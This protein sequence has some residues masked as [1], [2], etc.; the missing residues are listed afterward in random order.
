MKKSFMTTARKAQIAL[1]IMTAVSCSFIG[2]TANADFTGKDGTSQSAL[3][4]IAIGNNTQTGMDTNE[5]AIGTSAN[6]S[7]GS[8]IA[9]GNSASATSDSA[10]A[11]GNSASASAKNSVAIGTN[12]TATEDNVVSVGSSGTQRKIINVADGSVASDA[13]TVGQLNSK[14]GTLKKDGHYI[15]AKTWGDDGN[16]K[17]V[18]TPTTVN[19]NLENL[20]NQVYANTTAIGTDAD[21]GENKYNITT[22]TTT[23]TGEET[24]SAP[25]SVKANIGKLDTAMGNVSLLGDSNEGITGLDGKL[26]GSEGSGYKA[27]LTDG[28]RAIDEKVGDLNT[29]SKY[30]DEETGNETGKYN[31]LDGT[32]SLADNLEAV[33]TALGD[34]DSF[35]KIKDVNGK[36]LKKEAAEGEEIG[37]SVAEAVNAINGKIG[38][39]TSDGNYITAGKSVN[40]NLS[41]LDDQVATNTKAIARVNDKVNKVGAGAAALAALHPLDFNPD[42]K[43]SFAA[44]YGNYMGENAVALGAFYRPNEDVMVSVAGNMG[45]GENMVNA[46]VS[47]ALGSGSKAGTSKAAMAK[48][49]EA[50]D[51]QIESLNGTVAE[52]KQALSDQNEK[53]E[54]QSKE[55]AELK[56]MVQ[57]LAAK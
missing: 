12:S 4:A 13:A 8:A 49:I 6:A 20:D 22:T 9:L 7:G 54:Q 30:I 41:A 47:F 32:K 46:G 44:G 11:I 3:Y 10:I 39:L 43:F 50:Q 23:T 36:E 19:Q 24:T 33:D 14:V 34:L 40:D 55:I 45:N 57:A 29:E 48:K 52:Q 35:D 26:I 16:S 21:Y 56:A 25:T 51:A 27:N 18:D 53:L 1:A 2:L 37:V 5:I 42:D 38:D 28:L 15:T 31:V 17:L